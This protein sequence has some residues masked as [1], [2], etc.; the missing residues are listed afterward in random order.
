MSRTFQDLLQ[1]VEIN[2]SS[3]LHNMEM[4]DDDDILL[5]LDLCQLYLALEEHSTL[6]AT[7]EA[8][9]D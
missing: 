8:E 5:M 1:H 4:P 2:C 6:D 9:R 7:G 3:I